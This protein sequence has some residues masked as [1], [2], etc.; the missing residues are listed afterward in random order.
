MHESCRNMLISLIKNLIVAP[1][2]PLHP[3]EDLFQQRLL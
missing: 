2:G 1:V 3:K